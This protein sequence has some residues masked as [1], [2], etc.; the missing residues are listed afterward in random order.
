MSAEA[1]MARLDEA[2]DDC[3]LPP[4]LQPV[5]RFVALAGEEFRKRLFLT[6]GPEGEALC[7]RPDFTIPVCLEHLSRGGSAPARYSYRGKIFRKRRMIG[8]PEFEQAGTE[9]IGHHDEIATDAD[10]FGLAAECAAAVGLS[11]SI[12]VGD[13]HL[14]NALL[15]G[16]DLPPTWR[17]RLGAAFGD[18]ERLRASLARLSAQTPADGLAA[19]LA[20]ALAR[21]D[22]HEARAI[23]EAVVD[24]PQTAVSG[25]TTQD[26][27]TRILDEAARAGTKVNQEAAPLIDRFLSIRVPLSRAADAVHAFAEE[28]GIDLSHALD[29]FARR[30]GA[31]GQT[32]AAVDDVVFEARFGRRLN[33]Y[34]GFVFEMTN[35]GQPQAEVIAG[36]RYD[37]LIELLDP[38]RALAATGFSVWLDRIAPSS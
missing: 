30:A 7:L 35:K 22:A 5:D 2:S 3:I 20:P 24:L 14:F 11:P 36:G 32:G 9:W 26:I 13:A 18:D 15:D 31:L 28:A 21:M 23:V 19:R 10:V 12:K 33:Y 8:L 6:E 25:R 29:A 38:S 27:A 4:L 16:L 1:L 37:R 17:D 34:T